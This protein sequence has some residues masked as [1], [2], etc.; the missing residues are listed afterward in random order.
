MISVYHI[1]A[2]YGPY[3][4]NYYNYIATFLFIAKDNVP[5]GRDTSTREICALIGI[6]HLTAGKH[7]T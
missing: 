4:V 2:V 7:K 3:A 6:I 1:V 5:N